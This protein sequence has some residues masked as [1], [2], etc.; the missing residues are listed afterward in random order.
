MTPSPT[1]VYANVAYFRIPE[2]DTRSVAQQASEKE[3]L[4]ARLREATSG[5]P[6][7][8]R[9]V[10]DAD[11]GAALVLFGDPERA[12][13]VTQAVYRKGPVHAGLNYGP[14]ALSSR[15]SDA[16]VFGD[17]LVG[18]AA[19][20]R[21]ATPDRLLLTQDFAKALDA[22]APDRSAELETAGEFTDTRVRLHSFYTPNERKKRAGRR[23]VFFTAL[24]GIAV[25]LFA[26]VLAREAVQRFFPPPL[27]TVK[28]LVKPRADIFVDGVNK[29]RTPPLTE[30]QVAGGKHIVELRSQGFAPL[31]MSI[32]VQPGEQV[33]IAYNFTGAP[34]P[35]L[36]SDFKRK[37]GGS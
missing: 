14:L 28:L 37:L 5:L 3:S 22:T 36:W 15:G 25:I 7:G 11:E 24:A 10:L 13:E 8:E 32:N 31:K 20:A 19:A 4:E 9:V 17:G 23:K 35:S 21:F 33:T 30:I 1:P 2:F 27:A 18:A 29:G 34:K 26:G 16:R 12:L 6:A